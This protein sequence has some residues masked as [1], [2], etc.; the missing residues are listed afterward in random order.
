MYQPNAVKVQIYDPLRER[1]KVR[2]PIQKKVL[3]VEQVPSYK[4]SLWFKLPQK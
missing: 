1:R 4:N 3:A 2:P